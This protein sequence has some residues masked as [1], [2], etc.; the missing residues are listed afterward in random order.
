MNR[1]VSTARQLSGEDAQRGQ[2]ARGGTDLQSGRSSSDPSRRTL[3]A[4]PLGLLPSLVAPLTFQPI[5][6][7]TYV[8]YV[9][10][11]V[12]RRRHANEPDGYVDH[13]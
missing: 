1:P 9:V 6:T 5:R 7:T 4:P 2:A 11:V 10:Y 3:A 12:R 13:M 8:V